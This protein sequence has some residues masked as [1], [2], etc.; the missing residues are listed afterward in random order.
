VFIHN[1]ADDMT[2]RQRRTET[3]VNLIKYYAEMNVQFYRTTADGELQQT[4]VCFPTSAIVLSDSA[5]IDIDGMVKEFTLSVEN[6][7]KRGSNWIVDSVVDFHVTLSRTIRCSTF[8]RTP[9]EIEKRK[10]VLNI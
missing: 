4:T 10:A 6:I 3:Y 2:T 1:N 7:N 5:T 8:I 9:R